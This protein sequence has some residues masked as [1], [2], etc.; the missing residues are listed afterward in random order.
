M[1]VILL[2]AVGWCVVE[3]VARSLDKKPKATSNGEDAN[4]MCAAHQIA[5][6]CRWVEP[7]AAL[8]TIAKFPLAAWHAE[9]VGPK[10]S[11]M[12]RH[13]LSPSNRWLNSNQVNIRLVAAG[14]RRD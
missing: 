12:S 8:A 2:F 3:L 11:P 4:N 10:A 13:S 7:P 6:L 9:Q 14:K 1:F 5:R